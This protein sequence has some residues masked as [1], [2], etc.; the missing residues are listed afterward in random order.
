MRLPFVWTSLPPKW[1]FKGSAIIYIRSLLLLAL[2]L[3]FLILCTI[4]GLIFQCIS[5]LDTNIYFFQEFL[6][7]IVKHFYITTS[8]HNE[9]IFFV[10]IIVLCYIRDDLNVVL[11]GFS[12]GEK[13]RPLSIFTAHENETSGLDTEQYELF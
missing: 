2:C 11:K 5:K 10:H 1:F 6:K 7:P 3:Y 9:V 13:F 4:S 12:P 8:S